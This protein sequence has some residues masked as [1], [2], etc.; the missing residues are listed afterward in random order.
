VYNI[1]AIIPAFYVVRFLHFI[2]IFASIIFATSA[3]YSTFTSACPQQQQEKSV[4]TNQEWVDKESNIKVSF[5][6][7]PKRPLVGGFTDLNFKVDD[8]KR[9]T[10]YK[11]VFGSIV[12]TTFFTNGV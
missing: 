10:T 2:I 12:Q 4:T 8:L 3:I 1:Y 7:L 5:T 11:D 9:G 6:Y